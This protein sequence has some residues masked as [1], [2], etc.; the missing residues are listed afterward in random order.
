MIRIAI[1]YD[2]LR[3]VKTTGVSIV[4][5]ANLLFNSLSPIVEGLGG[6]INLLAA[7]CDGGT[8]DID[9]IY[10]KAG[11]RLDKKG[12]AIAVDSALISELLVIYGSFTNYD[13]VIGFGMTPALHKCLDNCSIPCVD[14][15]ISPLRY[16]SSTFLRARSSSQVI[17]DKI[18]KIA[19]SDHYFKEQA[20]LLGS[21]LIPNSFALNRMQS[22]RVGMIAGQ[23]NIDLAVVESGKIKELYE[24][25]DVISDLAQSV[26]LVFYKPH[27]AEP[28]SIGQLSYLSKALPRQKIFYC[29]QSIY[30]YLSM[31][32]LD[33]VAALSSGILSEST[34]FGVEGYQLIKPDRDF[35]KLLPSRLSGWQNINDHI[36]S[37]WFWEELFNQSSPVSEPTLI[38][39]EAKRLWSGFGSIE[40]SRPVHQYLP[41][42]FI[43]VSSKGE[44]I[45]IAK[46]ARSSSL[47][48]YGWHEVEE[49]G[50][51]S[52]GSES[53]IN[54][55]FK[56]GGPL[57]ISLRG[58]AFC[59]SSKWTFYQAQYDS[60]TPL[61]V[62][63]QPD[64]S[65]YCEV[66]LLPKVDSIYELKIHFN[67]P[68]SPS[69]AGLS[70]DTRKL[71]L[72][73]HSIKIFPVHQEDSC[74]MNVSSSKD[75][76]LF[77]G[78]R[79]TG[80][81][82]EEIRHDH[83]ARYD[84]VA[85]MIRNGENPKK[86][87]NILDVFCGNGY[88]S[89]LLGSVSKDIYVLGVD[90]SS[91]AIDLANDSY[92]A[93]NCMYVYKKFPFFLPRRA[94]DIVTCFESLEHVEDDEFLLRQ[95]VASLRPGG[96]LWLSVP[97]Q[98]HHDLIKNPHPFHFR[99]YDPSEISDRL[100]NRL[101][102]VAEYGQNVYIF[103]QNGVS[104][105]MLLEQVDMN[106]IPNR[107]GQV[108][109]LHFKKISKMPSAK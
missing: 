79:Q 91:A 61:F 81:S 57:L 88:G 48:T 20:Q 10:E 26:D 53:I 67:N 96:H 32:S 15:E 58:V 6:Q 54:F 18:Q 69:E 51:W 12:W 97:N 105:G 75:F 33:W 11:L 5:N 106:C 60:F 29:D 59:D 68:I 78:E 4:N 84:L 74:A 89:Y 82:L 21:K 39:S 35:S 62:A 87:L 108:A 44:E 7:S 3:T 102:L 99:H 23:T 77:S 63:S 14:L 56:S 90:G 36:F 95:M 9:L 92:A 50:V 22:L 19:V 109:I 8:V 94:F 98:K 31:P 86:K 2:V 80:Q 17:I 38:L 103:D 72:G 101:S 43:E 46:C 93:E 30:S 107:P 66:E 65:F 73:L 49:W 85:S 16:T 47:L 40:S 28:A 37:G 52:K 100:C 41:W 64:N 27:P 55:S 76:S 104:T 42:P 1:T 25:A 45:F 24:Y 70:V 34:F 13:L 71:A 83:I